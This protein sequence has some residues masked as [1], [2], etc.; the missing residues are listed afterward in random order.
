LITFKDLFEERPR[1]VAAFAL[2]TE[3]LYCVFQV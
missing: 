1:Y 3:T 2:V